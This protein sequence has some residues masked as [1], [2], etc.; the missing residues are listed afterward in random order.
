MSEIIIVS[1]DLKMKDNSKITPHNQRPSVYLNG[2]DG[3]F[4]N[5]NGMIQQ[6]RTLGEIKQF[7]YT[8]NCMSLATL[9]KC[10]VDKKISMSK[11]YTEAAFIINS[12]S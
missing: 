10:F 9:E 12:L 4:Y 2:H 1:T 3:Y 7:G 8:Q 5:K 6:I 11:Y